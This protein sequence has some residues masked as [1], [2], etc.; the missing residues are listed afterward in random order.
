MLLLLL[1]VLPVLSLYMH[2]VRVTLLLWHTSCCCHRWLL[3]SLLCA[4][5]RCLLL[6]V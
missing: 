3:V 2:A 4:E 6:Q 1:R 5:L